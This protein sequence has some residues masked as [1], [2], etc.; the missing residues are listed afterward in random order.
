MTSI[1]TAYGEG[2]IVA[3]ENYGLGKKRYRVAGVGFDVWM[4]GAEISKTAGN[5]RDRA[6]D[7][8]AESRDKGWKQHEQ[9]DLADETGDPYGSGGEGDESYGQGDTF[10]HHGAQSFD[11]EPSQHTWDNHTTLP[12][13]WR[14][15]FPVEMFRDEQTIS[16]DHEIDA[17][18]R[19]HSSDSRSGENREED[20]PYPGPAKHLFAGLFDGPEDG[21]GPE[22]DPHYHQRLEDGAREHESDEKAL[23]T[24]WRPHSAGLDDRYAEIMPIVAHND[25]V[26]QFKNDPYAAIERQGAIDLSAGMDHETGLDQV[27]HVRYASKQLKE[28]KWR[29][30]AQKAYRLKREGAVHVHAMDPSAIYA[31]VAGDHGDY[32]V[33][34]LRGSAYSGLSP[35]GHKKQAIANWK[36]S[37]DWGK[38]AF[39]RKFTFVG[40]LCSHGYAAYLTQQGEHMSDQHRRRKTATSVEDF[41]SWVKEENGDHIDMDAADTYL[42][43]LDDEPN[44]ADAEKI[45]EY[46]LDHHS[47]H[48]PR[49]YD[50][51]GYEYDN[52]GILQDKPGKLVPHSIEVPELSDEDHH[53]FT[54]LGDDRKTTGPEQIMA[55]MAHAWDVGRELI[56]KGEDKI[57]EHH[58]DFAWHADGKDDMPE[59]G[60]VHFSSL[61][62]TADENLLQKLRDLSQEEPDLGNMADHNQ[63][64]RNTVTELRDRGF[65]ASPMVASL[66]RKA[67]WKRADL[68]NG[69]DD[70]DP[71]DKNFGNTPPP[72]QHGP[73]YVNPG[74]IGA[75][76]STG[77]GPGWVDPNSYSGGGGQTP[78][79]ATHVD[80]SGVETLGG[81]NVGGGPTPA[82][83]AGAVQ[84][85]PKPGPTAPPPAAPA[86]GA[87]AANPEV[88][89]AAPGADMPFA[90]RDPATQKADAA[91]ATLGKP[92]APKPGGMSGADEGALGIPQP[93]QAPGGGN[94]GLSGSSGKAPGSMGGANEKALGLGAP[95]TGP[96]LPKI[97][98]ADFAL[99]YFASEDPES[100]SDD[101]KNTD[102]TTAPSLPNSVI[103]PP[104][105]AGGGP[106]ANKGNAYASPTGQPGTQPGN[107]S[108]SAQHPGRSEVGPGQGPAANPGALKN[109][110]PPVAGG[111]TGPIGPGGTGND[112]PG[113]KPPAPPALPGIPGLGGGLGG[114]QHQQQDM[115]LGG[116]PGGN[117]GGNPLLN[118]L[119]LGH[120]GAI[121][122]ADSTLRS[123][124]GGDWMDYPFAGSGPRRKDF[125]T[126][127]E[128]YV[129]Q[130]ERTNHHDNWAIDQDGDLIK[131][132]KPAQR[133]KQSS[134]RYADAGTGDAGYGNPGPM[135]G[136]AVV[137]APTGQGGSPEPAPGGLGA[138]PSMGSL[139][140]MSTASRNF[141]ADVE[142]TAGPHANSPTG[143]FGSGLHAGPG[144]DKGEYGI[145]E[146]FDDKGQEQGDEQQ[147]GHGGP[148]VPGLEDVA[149]KAL[150]LVA[151]ASYDSSDIV[152]QFQA[153][154]GGALAAGGG[155]FSDDGIA[156]AAQRLLKTAGRHYSLAEQRELEEEAH[157]HGARNL[158]DLDLSGTHYE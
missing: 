45:Y 141:W 9:H 157:I 121:F 14:P 85:A 76:E 97:S 31:T 90:Q 104:N 130:N 103:H 2:R 82:N 137:P 51:K 65:D 28:A 46:V 128:Q 153:S 123:T 42:Q 100:D 68:E 117:M 120:L 125:H 86:A 67:M 32:E 61:T 119:G 151:E 154:G 142:M 146:E 55:K 1:F 60:I 63:E 80:M 23:N 127:S 43:N 156:K 33:M 16:P 132:W 81:Q 70:V 57:N 62:F 93:L 30:V 108:W 47:E 58:P 155:S 10:W 21:P 41:K 88:S 35:T 8:W 109:L 56:A 29:D 99:R 53:Y 75:T 18:E 59:E 107:P 7:S 89:G 158:K 71:N 118:A 3:T 39:K 124:E 49:D 73:G 152:R 4:D 149:E 131:D 144:Y 143:Y 15:Q 44:K 12:Y 101:K 78:P 26:W 91:M 111:A 79:A 36:C 6:G 116:G 98:A 106:D 11:F 122:E 150:P 138:V 105:P 87:G 95:I 54:D 38:W 64:V 52:D 77:H 140:G 40:R 37:C 114:G 148:H 83:A 72:E 134:R 20:H 92:A 25:P 22:H 135:P 136:G 139:S 133:P 34:I 13:N 126:T 24:G 66:H 84:P 48:E 19:L 94:T 5:P 129:E 112:N 110:A 147:Q 27:D 102:G 50:V 74:P 69:Q 115:A 145:G 96:S 113:G 17:Q